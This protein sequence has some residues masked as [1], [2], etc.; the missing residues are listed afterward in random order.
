[1][2]DGY[3]D[4]LDHQLRSATAGLASTGDTFELALV[5]IGCTCG[6]SPTGAAKIAID[7]WIASHAN[8]LVHLQP[9]LERD[10]P[11]HHVRRSAFEFL[12]ELCRGLDVPLGLDYTTIDQLLTKLG[13]AEARPWGIPVSHGWWRE[14]RV[15]DIDDD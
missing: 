4:D 1:M 13:P 9:I 14:P 6:T 5:A 10:R 8:E 7:D 15:R 12:E 11:N 3:L 2:L